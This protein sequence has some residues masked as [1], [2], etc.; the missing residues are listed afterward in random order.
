MFTTYVYAAAKKGVRS[1]DKMLKFHTI[2][3]H[4][5]WDIIRRSLYANV[6]RNRPCVLLLADWMMHLFCIVLSFQVNC[7]HKAIYLLSA[8]DPTYP[9]FCLFNSVVLTKL[10]IIIVNQHWH[11]WG[12][13]WRRYAVPCLMRVI[14]KLNT[15]IHA[16]SICARTYMHILVVVC[17]VLVTICIFGGFV[18]CI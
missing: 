18:C 12:H 9:G 5:Y 14:W 4:W 17:L 8:T 7:F 13:F 15:C 3:P 11:N 2:Y 1:Y 10:S 6:V 16:Y